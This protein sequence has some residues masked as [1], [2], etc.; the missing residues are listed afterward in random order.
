MKKPENRCPEMCLLP[1]IKAG[2]PGKGILA[3]FFVLLTAA[4]IFDG[5]FFFPLFI[6]FIGY[7]HWLKKTLKH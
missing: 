6:S 3:Y 5:F 4:N 7:G 2:K 1:C